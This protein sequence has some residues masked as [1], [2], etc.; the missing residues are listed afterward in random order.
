MLGVLWHALLTIWNQPKV[1]LIF[2]LACFCIAVYLISFAQKSKFG[3]YKNVYWCGLFFT[4]FIFNYSGALIK[5]TSSAALVVIAISLYYIE[6]LKS[7]TLMPNRRATLHVLA[8]TLVFIAILIK[9]AALFMAIPLF[10]FSL[11][12]LKNN[13]TIGFAVKM[14]VIAIV[15][16]PLLFSVSYGALKS[17]VDAKVSN[18][19]NAIFIYDL[20]GMSNLDE[21][22]YLD[23]FIA[24]K[25]AKK[26][27][28]CYDHL[29][30]D[31]LAWGNCSFV[32]KD[33][34]N[35]KLWKND[36]LLNRWLYT[37]L[38]NPWT[39][40]KHRT[41]HLTAVLKTKGKD[42]FYLDR[43]DSRLP[44]ATDKNDVMRS[45]ANYYSSNSVTHL[46]FKPITWLLI[47]T[48][49]LAISIYR[50]WKNPANQISTL[51]AC[52]MSSN[53]VFFLTLLFFGVA[54]DFR[55][56]YT[57]IWQ[58]M[59]ASGLLFLSHSKAS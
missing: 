12:R 32:V 42:L 47:S 54:Y 58:V 25:N 34:A 39:Y 43:K 18:I 29:A 30:W 57:V 45:V 50:L 23:G 10:L 46:F 53:V 13:P 55:Y 56:F 44:W 11:L 20:S 48:F 31:N 3:G 19:K 28:A 41:T 49:L 22:N 5:D 7:D 14:A 26:L 38:N 59:I 6:V 36:E 27:P 21:K 40:V 52:L 51:T 16:T 35:H 2:N 33:I 15:L 17:A 4:P 8:S 37:V 24:Q 1:L 9:P